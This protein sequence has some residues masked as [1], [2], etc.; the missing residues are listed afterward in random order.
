MNYSI[1]VV[2]QVCV[3]SYWAKLDRNLMSMNLTEATRG[4][5]IGGTKATFLNAELIFP[6]TPDMN[7]KGYFSMMAVPVGIILI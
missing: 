3:D 6:I 2:R 4:D 5:S 7:I 1:L